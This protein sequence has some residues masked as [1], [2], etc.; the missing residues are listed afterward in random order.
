M[1]KQEIVMK[2]TPK[3]EAAHIIKNEID[4][5]YC[6]LTEEG[7]EAELVEDKFHGKDKKVAEQIFKYLDR[8]HKMLG[9]R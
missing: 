4:N 9:E 3:K 1:I 5:L 8:I 7:L 2:R 6:R